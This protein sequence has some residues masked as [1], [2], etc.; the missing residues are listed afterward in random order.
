MPDSKQSHGGLISRRSLLGT[1]AAVAATPA[2][3]EDCRIGP[4]PHE[5]GP[6]VWMEMDQVELDA[7]YD[8]STYAPMIDQIL[9]RYA[10]ASE[11]TRSRLVAP[12]RA[13]AERGPRPLSGKIVERSD[14]RI[15]P[16][17]PM[18]SGQC[19]ELRLSG[20]PFRQRR[21]ELHRAR[22]H[23]GG[24]CERRY[25]A[26]GR[27]GAPRNRLGLQK[28]RQFFRRHQTLLHRRPLVRGPPLRGR[29]R[30]R[31]AKG[32][33]VA[34]RHD[35]GRPLDERHLRFETGT[36]LGAQRLHQVRRR[37]GAILEFDTAHRH[38]ACADH[39]HLWHLRDARVPA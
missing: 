20:R 28:C 17:R 31:L 33:R 18:A 38:A 11:T 36:A 10:S 9:K 4:S 24:G 35:H 19:Q 8:Q 21:R 25:Q 27:A 13:D 14:L 7:A 29:A 39:R 2:S 26:D 12:L 6:K 22:L 37:Y 32:F 3:A 1:A 5:K 16:W 15:Y 23:P 30:D 34:T